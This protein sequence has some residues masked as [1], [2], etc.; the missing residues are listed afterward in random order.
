MGPGTTLRFVETA[1]TLAATARAG[2]LDPPSF[3]SPPR[4]AGVRRT[5]RR[6]PGGVVVSVVLRGRPFD[7]VASDMV[8]GVVAANHLSGA[9]ASRWRAALTAALTAPGATGRPG[10]VVGPPG[11]VAAGTL[12]PRVLPAAARVAER[13]TQAA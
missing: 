7:E 5:L 2:G 11:P 13:Q 10:E 9:A 3:R 8:D 4:V 1:R 6:F 12:P